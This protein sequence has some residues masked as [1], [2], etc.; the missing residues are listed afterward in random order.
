MKRMR[1]L[2]FTAV[3][4]TATIIVAAPAMAQVSVPGSCIQAKAGYGDLI[5]F[6]TDTCVG[7]PPTN[8]TVEATA[9]IAGRKTDRGRDVSATGSCGSFTAH[10]EAEVPGLGSPFDFVDEDH[11]GPVGPGS[12]MS[13]CVY[14]TAGGRTLWYV[15][16]TYTFVP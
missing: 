16:C 1:T 2:A 15:S 11:D 14:D 7:T 3:M 4:F 6:D 8:C 13:H 9:I 5:Q 10:A 12:P